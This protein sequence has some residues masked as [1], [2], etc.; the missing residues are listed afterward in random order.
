MWLRFCWPKSRYLLSTYNLHPLPNYKHTGNNCRWKFNSFRSQWIY[1]NSTADNQDTEEEDKRQRNLFSF[2]GLNLAK[3]RTDSAYW[4]HKPAD[5]CELKTDTLSFI[6]FL[7]RNTLYCLHTFY[8]LCRT[9]NIQ[10]I[11]AV[12]SSTV[13]GV[14]ESMKIQRLATKTQK[15][16]ISGSETSSASR[17]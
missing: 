7:L 17:V 11:S 10:E 4:D 15:K 1:E 5:V 9:I 2:Q 14:N 13:I 8:T 6:L 12:E 3:E 16:K